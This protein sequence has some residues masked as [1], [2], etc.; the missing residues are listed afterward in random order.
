MGEKAVEGDCEAWG[1]DGGD[2]GIGESSRWI[3]IN[4]NHTG[5][6]K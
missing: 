5:L 4:Q 6:C 2:V 3:L 1:E